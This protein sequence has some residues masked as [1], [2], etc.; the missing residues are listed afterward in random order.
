M[1]VDVSLSLL[2]VGIL[3]SFQGRLY[4][5]DKTIMPVYEKT[6]QLTQ[7]QESTVFTSSLFISLPSKHI[8]GV[9][10]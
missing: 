1:C 8:F 10:P 4:R 3:D 5:L 6:K 9:I 7:L 2:Q